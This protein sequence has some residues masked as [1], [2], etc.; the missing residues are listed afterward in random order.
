MRLSRP[1]LGGAAGSDPNGF[2]DAQIESFRRDYETLVSGVR[3]RAPSAKIVVANLPN[4]ASAVYTQGTPLPVRQ[5]IQ[6]LS[7]GFSTQA[8]N[9][10]ATQNVVVV[11]LL[12]NPAIHDV[13]LYAPDGMHG[14]DAGYALVADEMYKG[15]TQSGYPPPPSSCPEMTVVPPL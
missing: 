13:A 11:D 12:C 14:N 6:K 1:Y 10:M 3:A 8:I 2:A 7:V 5:L 9:P 4:L 15:V